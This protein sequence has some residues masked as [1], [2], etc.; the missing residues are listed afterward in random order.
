[1]MKLFE[2]FSPTSR[3]AWEEIALKELGKAD[4][5]ALRKDTFEGILANAL[6]DSLSHAPHS[7]SKQPGWVGVQELPLTTHERIIEWIKRRA[8]EG[9]SAIRLYY[10]NNFLFL[11]FHK[12]LI[13]QFTWFS[14]YYLPPPWAIQ[15]CGHTCNWLYYRPELITSPNIDLYPI[16]E[17][18]GTAVVQ[19]AALKWML[20]TNQPQVIRV[21]VGSHFL[22][23]IAKI[24]L[25]RS[26]IS[27][28]VKIYAHSVTWNKTAKGS[29]GNLVRL[30]LEGIAGI[31]GGCD[32]LEL[33]NYDVNLVPKDPN[34]ERYSRNII[35][36]LKHEAYLDKVIDP[37]GGSHVIEELMES[38]DIAASE[39]LERIQTEQD[40]EPIRYRFRQQ[41]GIGATSKYIRY[42]RNELAM[43]GLNV[44]PVKSDECRSSLES[45]QAYKPIR[46]EPIN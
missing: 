38:L 6:S 35:N 27:P 12:E 3:R 25:I 41:I 36:I 7:I 37:V 44:F 46:L 31:L 14:N 1:M 33:C 30:T 13:P 15:L 32:Y 26:W 43:V 29:H 23:E 45:E 28:D 17:S 16:G 18:G 34:A 40:K 22:I 42:C 9:W 19:L 24:R 20:E 5:N 2:E 8:D 10:S 11:H 21:P 39:L 4:L